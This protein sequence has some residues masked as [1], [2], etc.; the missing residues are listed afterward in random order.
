MP[1]SN[2]KHNNADFVNPG[3]WGTTASVLAPSRHEVL[4]SDNNRH[5]TTPNIR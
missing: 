4:Q 2:D 5:V 3:S 1:N